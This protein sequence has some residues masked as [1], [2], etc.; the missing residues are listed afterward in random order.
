MWWCPTGPFTYLPIHAAAQSTPFIQSYTSTLSALIQANV[1]QKLTRAGKNSITVTTVGVSEIPGK[2]HLH[3]PSVV[4]EING[5][6]AAVGEERTHILL[7]KDATLDKVSSHLV[8]STWLHLACHGQQD[9]DKPLKSHI[10]LYDGT[11]E[12]AQI[13]NASLPNAEFVFLSAC[14]TA[15]GDARLVNESMH[16]AGGLIFAGFLAAIGT[17]WNMSDSDGPKIAQDVYGKLFADGRN[18]NVTETAEALKMAVQKLR[19]QGA[20]F[21]QWMPFIHIGV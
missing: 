17:L 10:L 5:I 3:L 21:Q 7:D 12:L 20:P 11:L 15:T 8:T 18:P 2:A 9:P 19:D 14:Q 16:L 4:S 6:R 1:R 13:L